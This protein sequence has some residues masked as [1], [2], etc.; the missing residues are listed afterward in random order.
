MMSVIFTL[1][2]RMS[3]ISYTFP[4]TRGKQHCVR[5]DHAYLRSRLTQACRTC[6]ACPR[7]R[8][9]QTALARASPQLIQDPRYYLQL[10]FSSEKVV[11]IL[12]VSLLLTCY[13]LLRIHAHRRSRG[14]TADACSSSSSSR[15]GTKVVDR[16]VEK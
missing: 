6:C 5:M 10:T 15:Y 1:S 9:G 3:V 2:S 7:S 8:A 16:R 12:R 13:L 4:I 14:C 11:L